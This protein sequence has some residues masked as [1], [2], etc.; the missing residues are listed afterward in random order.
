VLIPNSVASVGNNAFS[1]CEKL[2]SASIACEK[3]G[4]CAFSQCAKLSSVT[5]SD[6]VRTIGGAAFICCTALEGKDIEIPSGVWSIEGNPFCGDRVNLTVSP[7]NKHF[8]M[9]DGNLYTADEKTLIA[10]IPKENETSFSVPESVTRI[11]DY[12]FHAVEAYQSL[13]LK[14]IY[15]S[16]SVQFIGYWALSLSSSLGIEIYFNGKKSEW[17]KITLT[18]RGKS[19]FSRVNVPIGETI[20]NEDSYSD[21][22]Y[23]KV[24]FKTLFGYTK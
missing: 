4:E 15:I 9:I 6:N 12:V 5:F 2:T 7:L 19:S 14:T 8:K 11:S 13:N 3:I 17:E 10:Y 22:I 18:A 20:K 1:N 21:R 23:S 16:K 24:H